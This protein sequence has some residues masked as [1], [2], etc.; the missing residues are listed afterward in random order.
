MMGRSHRWSGLVAG[1]LALVA[2][3]AGPARAQEAPDRNDPGLREAMQRFEE[4]MQLY[5]R[6][7]FE[8]ALAEFGQVYEL[9]ESHPR[10]F[11]VLYNM[12]MTQEELFRYDEA[13]ASYRRY[14]EAEGTDPERRAEAQRRMEGLLGRLATLEITVNVPEA[15]VWVDDRQVGTAP[16]SVQVTGG[17][18][19]VELRRE[20]YSPA[21]QDVQLAARTTESL[22]FRLDR[23]FAGVS[24]AFFVVGASLTVAAAAVGI[25]FGASAMA[26]NAA[27]NDQLD[28]DD[29]AERYQV[30]QARIDAMNETALIADILYASAGVLGIASVVLL[31]VTDWG[32]ETEVAPEQA[33]LELTPVASPTQLGLSLGGRF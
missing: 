1:V 19:V 32:S 13:L 11:M 30:T 8:S 27:L 18:H 12:A 33:T 24:P 21:R 29:P 17:R 7:D 20:G 26:D 15:E 10:R 4:A 14:L 25:G 23:T 22:D 28:S 9:L 2:L 31:F 3:A 16:G 6:G 5:E